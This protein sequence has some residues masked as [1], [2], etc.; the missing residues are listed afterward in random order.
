[1]HATEDV[2][3]RGR[4]RQ[5][6]LEGN[7]RAG[8]TAVIG[9]RRQDDGVATAGRVCLQA[10]RDWYPLVMHLHRFSLLLLG[11]RFIMILVVV[12]PRPYCLVCGGPGKKHLRCTKPFVSLQL[13][14]CP[15]V[16]VGG[17]GLAFLVIPSPPLILIVGDILTGLLVKFS[18]FLGSVR[19]PV[20]EGDLVVGVSPLWRC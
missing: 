3:A 7:N 17:D 9:R 4:V 6:D 20:G 15:T 8:E 12:L 5:G 16:W 13:L 2:V 18:S 1:M 19:W 14:L 11:L 10:C